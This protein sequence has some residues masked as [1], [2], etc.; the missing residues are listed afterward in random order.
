M[1]LRRNAVGAAGAAALAAALATQLEAAGR[2]A[3]RKR[4]RLT[5]ASAAA[6]TPAAPGLRELDLG[7]N[8]GVG[9]RG[10]VALAAALRTN[11]VLEVLALDACRVG[12]YGAGALGAVLSEKNGNRTLKVLR[13][14]GNKLSDACVARLVDAA[15]A[16][17]EALHCEDGGAPSDGENADEDEAAR[18][19]GAVWAPGRG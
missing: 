12:D 17:V 15:A 14:S 8:P 10:A 18:V 9:S 5:D 6:P 16:T 11:G 1:G 3:A 4:R 13:V 7:E 2:A 19:A